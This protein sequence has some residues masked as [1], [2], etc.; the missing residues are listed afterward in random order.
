MSLKTIISTRECYEGKNMNEEWYEIGPFSELYDS[1]EIDTDTIAFS[2]EAWDSEIDF[3][4]NVL[5]FEKNKYEKRYKTDVLELVLCGKVGLWNG[6]CVGGK[7]VSFD[8]P[9]SMGDVDDIEVTMDEDRTLVV[10]GHHHDGSHHMFLYFLTESSM[11]KAGIF[12]TYEYYGA[13]N[14]TADDYEAIFDKLNPVKLSKNNE[15]CSL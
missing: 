8:N 15:H 6:S 10:S 2:S 11:K 14:F 7:L 12:N 5:A 4:N 3:F 1:P 13:D 9:I